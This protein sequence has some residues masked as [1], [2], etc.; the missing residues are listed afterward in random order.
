M[1]GFAVNTIDEHGAVDG[2]SD[3]IGR[4]I[5]EAPDPDPAL[6]F[7]DP[8]RLLAFL[9]VSPRPCLALDRILG[10]GSHDEFESSHARRL[11]GAKGRL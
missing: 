4:L 10:Y 2:G 8:D 7:E 1:S 9:Y 3:L 5:Q 11:A 6:A